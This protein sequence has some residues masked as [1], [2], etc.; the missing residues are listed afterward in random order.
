M[1]GSA[2]GTC[3][4][5]YAAA[6]TTGALDNRSVTGIAT[7]T[8]SSNMAAYQDT[9]IESGN[10]MNLSSLASQVPHQFA[11]RP[12]RSAPAVSRSETFALPPIQSQTPTSRAKVSLDPFQTENKL[13]KSSLL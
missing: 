2:I 12:I 9:G 4:S 10:L 8:L 5:E 13:R 11:A 6:T 1:G 7:N 3:S